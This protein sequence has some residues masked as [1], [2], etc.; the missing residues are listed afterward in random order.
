MSW[1]M[2]GQNAASEP[3]KLAG[4]TREGNFEH[5]KVALREGQYASV[6]DLARMRYR[7]HQSGEVA[8]A[9]ST[10][11]YGVVTAV[12]R[13]WGDVMGTLRKL[14]LT[15]ELGD[16]T[17]EGTVSALLRLRQN[18][19]LDGFSCWD[20]P[21]LPLLQE[22][23]H[24]LNLLPA[25]MAVAVDDPPALVEL[26]ASAVVQYVDAAVPASASAD[27]GASAAGGAGA[28]AAGSGAG[29]PA[30][31]S[32]VLALAGSFA[33][34]N[35]GGT[36]ELLWRRAMRDA[37]LVH[38]HSV[39]HALGNGAEGN[40]ADAARYVERAKRVWATVG[41]TVTP[42]TPE[43]ALRQALFG[44]LFVGT[45]GH[46]DAGVSVERASVRAAALGCLGEALSALAVP[47]DARARHL[48]A[49]AAAVKPLADAVTAAT[50]TP[51][52]KAL[53]TFADEAT[54]ASAGAGSTGGGKGAKVGAVP[55]P[56]T[57][58]LN[59][60]A[61]AETTMLMWQGLAHVAIALGGVQAQGVAGHGIGGKTGA[62][63]A[64]RAAVEAAYKSV[65]D[66]HRGL[67]RGLNVNIEKAK[68]MLLG[69]FRLPSCV[70]TFISTALLAHLDGTTTAAREGTAPSRTSLSPAAAY[71]L[72]VAFESRRTRVR[73]LEDALVNVG[74]SYTNTVTK[75][76]EDVEHRTHL[77]AAMVR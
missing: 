73:K 66:V 25:G 36:F 19:D 45:V 11:S 31:V 16:I 28:A 10:M 65:D 33:T 44:D 56:A 77:L 40:T 30:A 48:T 58:I 3:L 55:P 62:L 54:A 15:R 46:L 49:L 42:P 68:P 26:F 22:A 37:M 57:Q 17:F 8:V 13:T 72:E 1:W 9:R 39:L 47:P 20:P 6:L 51:V 60:T 61:L 63:A 23:R 43:S 24:G 52:P 35:N 41:M 32:R 5:A 21:S 18:D 74:A 69:G 70:S 29:V 7:V 4:Q 12:N 76:R 50:Y 38:R 27:G 2:A 75:L 34:G 64:A 67:F 53:S 14:T 59:P 71:G